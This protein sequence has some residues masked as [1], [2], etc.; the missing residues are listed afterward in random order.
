MASK[1][2]KI[3]RGSVLLGREVLAAPHVL[4]PGQLKALG[5]EAGIKNYL[6]EG[7]IVPTDQAAEVE[8]KQGKKMGVSKPAK[9][10]KSQWVLDPA[11]LEGKELDELLA[12][13]AERDTTGTHENTLTDPD[14]TAKELVA[15]LSKD[16]DGR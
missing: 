5:G 12:M 13:V 2:Y 16:F 14:I 3:I 6:R 4:T 1:N 11:T 8:A 10:L 9:Q 7:R 15:I